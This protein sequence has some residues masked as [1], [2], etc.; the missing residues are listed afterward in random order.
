MIKTQLLAA[1]TVDNVMA[2]A[3]L[4][5]A[6]QAIWQTNTTLTKQQRG[7]IQNLAYGV[8]RQ[9]AQLAAVSCA[10]LNKPLQ[11]K[12]LHHLLLVGLYQLN[13]S[14]TTS[15][16]IV[17]HAVSASRKLTANA[18]I[19]GLVNA[20]LRNFIRQQDV[21][22]EQTM[23]AETTKFS[24]PQWWI[25]KLQQ[26]YPH[27]YQTILQAGNQHPPM[28]IRVN[29]RRIALRDY[30]A[31]LAADGIES[32]LLW[33]NALKLRKPVSVEKLPGFMDGLISVQDAGAQLAAPLLAVSN[34]M[35][36]L[37][38]C[39][40]PG[41][42]STHL[43]E[44]ADIE[45]T[46]LDN[47]A[48][49]LQ[50]VKE[51]LAR[52]KL[53]AHQ[54]ICGDARHPSQWWHGQLFDRIMVDAPCSASGVVSRHPDIKWHRKPSDVAHFAQTQAAILEGMWPLLQH[55]AELLYITCSIFQEENNLLV[56]KFLLDHPDANLLPVAHPQLNDRQL[57][58][59]GHHDGFFYALLQKD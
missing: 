27:Q 56:T 41:G 53:S 28:T 5:D 40:A 23:Q 15:H 25:D 52:L 17:N 8:L 32:E 43:L 9:Y 59:N 30:Q 11:D 39:A 58:P 57:L 7:A 24:Y 42:K 51:N 18:G 46:I 1:Q 55:G 21:L 36:V 14:K 2:G 3:N 16:A 35:R 47:N 19:T 48:D 13:Y 34:G 38:A 33:D 37:D 22:L 29:Q 45:L 44:M 10:L 20:V 6:L 26:H 54:I 4:T 12:R 50:K 31:M 49:R